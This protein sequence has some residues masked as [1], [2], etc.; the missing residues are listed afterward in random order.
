MVSVSSH[1]DSLHRDREG[2]E[3][4][5]AGEVGWEEPAQPSVCPLL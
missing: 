3:W 5:G 2:T 1:I 4:L